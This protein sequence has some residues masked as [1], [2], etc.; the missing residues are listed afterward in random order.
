M[1]LLLTQAEFKSLSEY[2]LDRNMTAS[3][4]VRGFIRP[5]LDKVAKG[6]K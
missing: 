5:L 4:V 3:E 6:G 2:A 1:Q